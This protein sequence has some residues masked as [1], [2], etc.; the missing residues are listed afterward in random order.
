[1]CRRGSLGVDL[2]DLVDWYFCHDTALLLLL[3]VVTMMMIMRY[4]M[5]IKLHRVLLL[6][7]HS[8]VREE[9]YLLL[10]HT[11]LHPHTQ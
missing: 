8:V 2:T 5:D 4:T 10:T 11:H 9:V 7:L 1:M 6:L 3:L